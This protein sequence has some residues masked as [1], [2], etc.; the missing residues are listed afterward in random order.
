VL[1]V[2]PYRHDLAYSMNVRDPFDLHRSSAFDILRGSAR[3]A[4][5]KVTQRVREAGN[6]AIEVGTQAYETGKQ[7][8][9][10]MSSFS[11]PKNV[12]SFTSPQRE[13]ENKVWGSSGMSAR[14][15]TVHTNG[16]VISG[17]QDRMGDFFEKN[18]D[19]PLYKDKPYSYASSRRRR[20]IMRRKRTFG[21]LGICIVAV[22]YFW[23]FFGN[24]TAANKRAKGA[25]AWLQT[26]ESDSNVDWLGRRER[27]VEAFKLSWDAYDRYAWGPFF[28]WRSAT[29]FML[30]FL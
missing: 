10:D 9:E 24:D 27:V 19:L 18:R 20:P 2:A 29:H 12:P 5:T 15:S 3:Q 30:T 1:H 16:G 4:A 14:S 8:F 25:W 7:T 28:Y 13:I 11:I 17:M 6:Q 22:L 21:I 23:G 26:P